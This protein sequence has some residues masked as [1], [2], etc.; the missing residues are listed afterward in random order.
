MEKVS[1]ANIK[2]HIKT[3]LEIERQGKYASYNSSEKEIS[4]PN[5]NFSHTKQLV[6]KLLCKNNF[7]G[8]TSIITEKSYQ[9]HLRK[10]NE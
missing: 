7:S 1:Y 9:N 4:T 10:K 5:N 8:H 3:A 6:N 2:Y